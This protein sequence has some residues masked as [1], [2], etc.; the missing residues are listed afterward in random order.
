[1]N[2][3]TRLPLALVAA[4]AAAAAGCADSSSTE[5]PDDDPEG[6]ASEGAAND[7]VIEAVDA[8]NDGFAERPLM[9]FAACEAR[10]VVVPDIG[11]GKVH[12]PEYRCLDG[13]V[14]V[15]T[16]DWGIEGAVCCAK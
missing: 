1:M 12:R 11:N 13:R 4:L 10:G 6:V 5:G 8:D 3:L 14:P 7:D 9:T 15:G 16:V 2:L